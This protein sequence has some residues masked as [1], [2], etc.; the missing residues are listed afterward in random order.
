[1]QC[2][3]KRRGHHEV[4]L[5][6]HAFA[7]VKVS[8]YPLTLLLNISV[9]LLREFTTNEFKD[10]AHTFSYHDLANRPLMMQRSD[11]LFQSHLKHYPSDFTLP[12]V[13]IYRFVATAKRYQGDE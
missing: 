1:M 8:E 2:G 11:S 4:S 10:I 7:V 13:Y 3:F 9:Q 5:V 6:H 12:A